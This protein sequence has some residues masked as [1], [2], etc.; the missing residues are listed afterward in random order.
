MEKKDG[1][2]K[3]DNSKGE[4]EEQMDLLNLTQYL[5]YQTKLP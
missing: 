3:E 2:I 1:R 4:E 5:I